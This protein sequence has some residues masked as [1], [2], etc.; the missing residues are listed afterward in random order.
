MCQ[1][2]L[3]CCNASFYESNGD[4]T[5]IGQIINKVRTH[6]SNIKSRFRVECQMRYKW[7]PNRFDPSATFWY[8]SSPIY[9]F[10]EALK[11]PLTGLLKNGGLR[12]L[13]NS[14]KYWW[15][16]RSG[17]YAVIVSFSFRSDFVLC[18]STKGFNWFWQFFSFSYMMK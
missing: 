9:K 12:E 1:Q 4:A 5:H 8:W 15:L 3:R 16:C 2:V 13:F 7:P 10:Y 11:R 6:M 18:R 17:L 14:M